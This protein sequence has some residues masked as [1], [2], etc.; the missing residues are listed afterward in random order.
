M[1]EIGEEK[2]PQMV[3]KAVVLRDGTE[4]CTVEFLDFGQEHCC[5][6]E[7]KISIS[8]QVSSND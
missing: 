2:E 6:G 4:L 3:I 1:V 8:I 7:N 5:F